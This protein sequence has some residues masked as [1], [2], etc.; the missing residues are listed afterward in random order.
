M[1]KNF[2][3]RKKCINNKNINDENVFSYEKLNVTWR[4]EP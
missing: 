4:F 3:R 2:A 1:L